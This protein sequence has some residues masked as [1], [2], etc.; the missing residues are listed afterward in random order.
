MLAVLAGARSVDHFALLAVVR[1]LS[2]VSTRGRVFLACDGHRIGL[3]DHRVDDLDDLVDRQ[4]RR[5]RVPPDRL[6]A[7]RLVDADG[8]QSPEGSPTT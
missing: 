2:H 1:A 7:A 3:Q 5:A 4:I 8:P 6:R